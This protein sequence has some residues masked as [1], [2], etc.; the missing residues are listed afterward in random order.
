[1]Y[2]LAFGWNDFLTLMP[3]IIAL[4]VWVIGRFAGQV[5]QKP[6]QRGAAPPKPLPQQ[7]PPQGAGD[8]LQSEIDQFL[9][10]AQAARE[11]R[12]A[13]KPAKA[14]PAAGQVPA[15]GQA[16]GTMEPS[17]GR[18]G[19][20]QRQR[21][22]R[23]APAAQQPGGSSRREEKPSSSRPARSPRVEV[24][25][26]P[27]PTPPATPRESVAQHVAETLDDSV[28]ARRTV[29][30]S[31]VKAADDDF[32][33]HMQRV[34]QHDVGS[35]KDNN[36]SPGSRASV[37]GASSATGGMSPNAAAA[38]A[39]VARQLNDRKLAGDIALLLAGRK[40]LR[41]AVILTEIFQRPERWED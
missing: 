17:S 7:Q 28:F 16:P 11:G 33:A 1:M 39:P 27:T 6:P 4:L 35:L 32:R 37:T 22:S 30:L 15:T 25:R 8:P 29:Q 38:I 2:L 31:R 18:P 10:Q 12:A 26:A 21:P 41:D 9:R 19:N 13:A 40:G 20:V 24:A 36:L 14:M 3:F 5:P 23:R 34:F